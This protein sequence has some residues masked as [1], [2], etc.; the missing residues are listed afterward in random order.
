[1]VKFNIIHYLMRYFEYNAI[2]INPA[3]VRRKVYQ[4]EM[5]SRALL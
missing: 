4:N 3:R 5:I 2:E 1:M